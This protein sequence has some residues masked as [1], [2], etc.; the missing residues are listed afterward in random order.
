MF[1]CGRGKTELFENDDVS[2]LDPVY[3]R[4][5]K[6]REIVICIKRQGQYASG[7]VR[8]CCGF[9]VVLF[10]F[11]FPFSVHVLFHFVSFLS[12][13]GSFTSRRCSPKF[14]HLSRILALADSLR[15]TVFPAIISSPSSMP[16]F[17]SRH[18][19][20]LLSLRPFSVSSRISLL[21]DIV[22]F[23][24]RLLSQL[25]DRCLCRSSSLLLC[26]SHLNSCFLPFSFFVFPDLN[27]PS[28]RYFTSSFLLT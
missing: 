28:T 24:F 20:L 6:W 7:R 4:E 23:Y 1:P 15:F 5:R 19:P 12:Y 9:L 14:C 8:T 18:C 27:L 25:L 10:A 3:P 17:A 22:C 11:V 13:P 16:R 21:H 26:L 2:V